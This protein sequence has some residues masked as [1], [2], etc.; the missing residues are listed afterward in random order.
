[1]IIVTG[2]LNMDQHAHVRECTHTN[3]G[4]ITHYL[5]FFVFLHDSGMER[6]NL[7]CCDK[8]RVSCCIYILGYGQ[9]KM[10]MKSKRK[11]KTENIQKYIT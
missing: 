5:V 8:S 11:K 2:H 6:L 10:Q 4:S 1:M 3:V 9:N 7:L